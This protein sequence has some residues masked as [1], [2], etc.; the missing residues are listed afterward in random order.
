MSRTKN[1]NRTLASAIQTNLIKELGKQRRQISMKTLSGVEEQKPVSKAI[2][3]PLPSKYV[4][5]KTAYQ[6]LGISK[7]SFFRLKKLG[8]FL[9]SPVTGR[10]HLD[11]LDREARG[12]SVN[13]FK[14]QM[15]KE[16]LNSAAERRPTRRRINL[17]PAFINILPST[18]SR[19]RSKFAYEKQ[20]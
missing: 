12:H 19:S 8:H 13:E 15:A 4:D 11:D 3:Q 7:A 1:T 16:S 17:Q 2:E 14:P 6:H 9:P 5:T 20:P 18:I 10:Y